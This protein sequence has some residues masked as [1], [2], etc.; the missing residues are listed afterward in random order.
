MHRIN[1]ETK[2]CKNLQILDKNN[3]IIHL[4]ETC[5]LIIKTPIT[6][7][8]TKDGDVITKGRYE[9]NLYSDNEINIDLIINCNETL[10]ML[11][12]D[13]NTNKKYSG[14]VLVM[15]LNFQGTGVLEGLF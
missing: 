2:H 14:N 12:V 7:T 9:W 15:P 11:C 13:V 8:N 6:I 4:S 5:T 10:N 1:T 3:N